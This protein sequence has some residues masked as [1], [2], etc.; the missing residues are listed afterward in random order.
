MHNHP[1]NQRPPIFPFHLYAVAFHSHHVFHKCVVRI[2]LNNINQIVGGDYIKIFVICW[3]KNY[4]YKNGQTLTVFNIL[5]Q[6]K[7]AL[8]ST[9]F[10]GMYVGRMD[11]NL[12]LPRNHNG[13]SVSDIFNC[14]I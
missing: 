2:P 14:C 8:K 7:S 5:A 4:C 13:R 3:Y 12:H 1:L 6:L 9:Q 11:T 10:V